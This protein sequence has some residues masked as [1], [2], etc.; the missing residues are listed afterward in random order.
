MYVSFLSVFH[1]IHFPFR[2]V[3]KLPAWVPGGRVLLAL[4][5]RKQA[6]QQVVLI[7]PFYRQFSTF[8]VNV[9]KYQLTRRRS[10][11]MGQRAGQ[12]GKR[13]LQEQHMLLEATSRRCRHQQKVRKFD[14]LK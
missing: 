3:H 11:L 5:A 2:L 6:A 12:W 1:K 9:A 10:P 14:E 4:L 8:L 13:V 7:N